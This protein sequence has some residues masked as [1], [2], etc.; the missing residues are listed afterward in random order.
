MPLFAPPPLSNFPVYIDD[1]GDAHTNDNCD[2][3]TALNWNRITAALVQM[4]FN[5]Y[6]VLQTGQA[7]VLTH[8]VTGSL[9]SKVL[10]KAFD[11]TTSSPETWLKTVSMPAF[12]TEEKDLFDGHPLSI[13]N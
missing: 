13:D 12:S 2:H 7:G 3:I 1:W 5:S 10:L 4:G 9:R 8:P 11:I 6:T